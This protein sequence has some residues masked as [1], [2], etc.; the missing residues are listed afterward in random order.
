MPKDTAALALGA[1]AEG[2]GPAA[3]S[4]SDACEGESPLADSRT[5]EEP[6][7]G[8]GLYG[9]GGVCNAAAAEFP[10]AAAGVTGL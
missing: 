3:G 10:L 7:C 4:S 1:C 2:G 9:G 8:G 5:P 6:T